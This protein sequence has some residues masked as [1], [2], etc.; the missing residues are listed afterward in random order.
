M[1]EN[2]QSS[3]KAEASQ[4]ETQ[5]QVDQHIAGS[6]SMWGSLAEMD[7][8]TGT[9]TRPKDFKSKAQ[10]EKERK[11]KELED[12]DRIRRELLAPAPITD[13][14][15][16]EYSDRIALQSAGS[17]SEFEIQQEKEKQGKALKSK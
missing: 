10:L 6:N 2:S 9:L 8:I 15:T 16:R 13:T 12:R 7:H 3:E 11:A 4:P 5:D 17:K 14:D 1:A